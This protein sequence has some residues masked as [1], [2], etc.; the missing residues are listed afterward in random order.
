MVGYGGLQEGKEGDGGE[1]DGGDVRFEH[2]TP[3]GEGF[4][5]PELGFEGGGVDV[6]RGCFGAGNAGVGYW[7]ALADDGKEEGGI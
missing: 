6:F 5:V 7:E 3:F 4:V 1:V 2:V